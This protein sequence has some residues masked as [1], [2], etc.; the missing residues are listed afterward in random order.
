MTKLTEESHVQFYSLCHWVIIIIYSISALLVVGGF[1]CPPLG[2][3]SNSVLIAVG[4]LF[5]F[6]GLFVIMYSIRMHVHAKFSYKDV[7]VEV[8]KDKEGIS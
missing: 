2:E 6:A 7:S 4:E 3:I 5:A 1:L 8:N